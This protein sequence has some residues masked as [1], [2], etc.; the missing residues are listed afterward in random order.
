MEM[1]EWCLAVLLGYGRKI[2]FNVSTITF[3]G[4]IYSGMLMCLESTGPRGLWHRLRWAFLSSVRSGAAQALRCRCHLFKQQRLMQQES[5]D[6]PRSRLC[7]CRSLP[8]RIQTVRISVC[9]ASIWQCS[10]HFG[11][12]C[13]LIFARLSVEIHGRLGKPLTQCKHC[14]CASSQLR[15]VRFMSRFE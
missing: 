9:F 8:R 10:V 3:P 5:I 1:P 12:W 14:I 11:G 7:L 4:V 6:D 2:L 15:V 13:I